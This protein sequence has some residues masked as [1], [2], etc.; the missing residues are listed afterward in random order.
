MVS[1]LPQAQR[2]KHSI[3]SI[4]HPVRVPAFRR[5]VILGQRQETITRDTERW[6]RLRREIAEQFTTVI[7]RA[8]AI[9]IEHQE[10]VIDAGAGPGCL[11]LGA[12]VV[13]VEENA[14]RGVS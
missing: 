2:A 12:I 6:I 4:N 5:F 9:A 13:E 1:V 8:V 11:L 3:V 7:N 14:S 10:N